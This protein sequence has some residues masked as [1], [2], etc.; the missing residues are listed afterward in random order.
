VARGFGQP[1]HARLLA[2][3]TDSY[4]AAVPAI[5][6]SR[7]DMI[8]VHLGKALF[9]YTAASPALLARIDAFLA[10]QQRDPG[11]ARVLIEGRDVVTKTLRGRALPSV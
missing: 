10:A 3:Y 2:R 1:E 8:K 6:S 11:L 9:P 7:T 5:W 4:F